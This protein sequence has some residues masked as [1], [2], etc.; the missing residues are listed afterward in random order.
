MRRVIDM[1]FCWTSNPPNSALAVKTAV[2]RVFASTSESVSGLRRHSVD[3][4]GG[5]WSIA[6]RVVNI[7]LQDGYSIRKMLTNADKEN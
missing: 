6:L 1:N 3:A 2:M 7:I 4:S 5:L